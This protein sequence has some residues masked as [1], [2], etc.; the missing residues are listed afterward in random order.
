MP[1]PST[2]SLSAVSRVIV[3]VV[4]ALNEAAT[5]AAVVRGAAEHVDHVVVVNDGSSDETSELA[6]AAGAI[7]VDHPRRLGVGAAIS[8]GLAK[9]DE[10]GATAVVQTDGDGQHDPRSIP[11]LLAPLER[12]AD[13]VVGSRFEHGFEMGV[14]RRVVLEVFARLISYRLGTRLHDPTSGFRA[15]SPQAI[16]TLT[17]IFPLKYLSDTVE[18]LYLA[19]DRG[20]VIETV[21]VR[22]TARVAGKPS[23]GLVQ[24]IGYALRVMRIVAAHTFAH[25]RALGN[26]R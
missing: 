6:A 26:G 22:M 11:D 9:A 12:G 23:A 5:I 1:G 3:A 10:L 24:S 25:R 7:V 14:V 15:F 4:P 21:P 18:V 20:L 19:A 16:A 13:L 2:R 17:P 8:S